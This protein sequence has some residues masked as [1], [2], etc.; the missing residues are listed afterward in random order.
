MQLNESEDNLIKCLPDINQILPNDLNQ[1][2]NELRKRGDKEVDLLVKETLV[3]H[4]KFLHVGRQGY[5]H[6]LDIADIIAEAPELVLNSNTCV[7]T[8]LDEYPEQLKNYFDPLEAPDWVDEAKLS[9]SSELWRKDMLAIVS[10]L[11]AIS[12][13]ACY[14]MKKG[15]PALYQTAKLSSRRYIYQR[16]YETG[17]MLDA[18]LGP[19]GLRI[20]QDI[21]HSVD[22]HF[23]Q[24]I[25][26][27][28]PD[29]QWE[30]SG[31]TIARKAKSTGKLN[32]H[33]LKKHIDSIMSCQQ[34]PK[35]YLWGKGYITAKKVRFLHASM[36]FIL[37]NPGKS[38]AKNTDLDQKSFAEAISQIEKPY[39]FE[40]LG[41]PVNQEDLAYTLL[42]FAYCIPNGL[43]KWGIK[44]NAEEKQAFLHTWKIIGYTL[45]IQENLLTDDWEEAERLFNVI[46]KRQAGESS[47]AKQLTETLIG[48]FQDYLPKHFGLNQGI[49]ARLIKEQLGS[50]HTKMVMP[51]EYI[52][53]SKGLLTMIVFGTSMFV[54][55]NYFR[56]RRYLYKIPFISNF[57]KNL[58]YETGVELVNSWRDVYSR[59]PFY[60]SKKADEWQI[61]HGVNDLFLEE[62]RQWRHRLF[63][64]M[65]IGLGS[66]IAASASITFYFT[67]WFLDKHDYRV[68]SGW[69]T[70]VLIIL[71]A[72]ILHYRVRS[73]SRARPKP[74]QQP[75]VEF[76]SDTEQA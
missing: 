54:L 47:Q 39:D 1:Y 11:Y 33:T 27:S 64:T 58:L 4:K 30:K 73:V 69:S 67:F 31:R 16:I 56:V 17:L 49:A 3:P 28:D 75:M 8:E 46:Q 38:P 66:L 24:A 5:N 57:L 23:E 44:W 2:F 20:V 71:G 48:F 19:N 61:M 22:A 14:L 40:T 65:A 36:R 55:K 45:G 13:P 15:I 63:N 70:L 60:V 21:D 62:L 59:K 68:I 32:P 74:E 12:L 9:L 51:E 35:R 10:V 37:M 29:G 41:V 18:V 52:K 50:K 7:A 43:G 76:I 6:L 53:A 34:K 72:F 42:T 26:L 25:K